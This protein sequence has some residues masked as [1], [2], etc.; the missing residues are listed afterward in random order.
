MVTVLSQ[1][2]GGS[3]LATGAMATEDGLMAV[4]ETGTKYNVTK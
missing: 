1:M 3:L 4:T 2:D